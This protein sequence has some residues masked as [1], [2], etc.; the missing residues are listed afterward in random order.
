MKKNSLSKDKWKRGETLESLQTSVSLNYMLPESRVELENNK[1]PRGPTNSHK[2]Q[3]G[4]VM[5]SA[6][7]CFFWTGSQ[8]NK[9]LLPTI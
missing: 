4:L 9:T 3:K 8:H 5:R 7:S 2:C 1:L 6:N